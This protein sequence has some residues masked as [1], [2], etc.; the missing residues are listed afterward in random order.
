MDKFVPL[1]EKYKEV[2]IEHYFCCIDGF[3]SKYRTS[4][5]ETEIKPESI[6]ILIPKRKLMG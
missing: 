4:L 6:K 1:K 2:P 5:L 3:K